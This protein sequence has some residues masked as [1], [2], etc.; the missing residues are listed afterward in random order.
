MK[1]TLSFRSPLSALHSPLSTLHSPL[2]ALLL[3]LLLSPISPLHSQNTSFYAVDSTCG[4]D[5]FYTE[6]IQTT[7]EGNLYG[8]RRYD[9]TVLTPPV[10]AYVG[11]FSGGYCQ[12]WQFDTTT[13]PDPNLSEPPLLAGLID[14][15]GRFIVPCAFSAV[16]LPS[17]GR[18]A[19]MQDN[20]WGFADLQGR[21]VVAPRFTAVRP[22]SDGRAAVQTIVDSVFYFGNYIDTLGHLLFPNDYFQNTRSFVDGYATAMRYDRWGVIDRDGNEI[23]P[24]AFE[25][26]TDPD[27]HTVL[28]GHDNGELALFR[29]PSTSPRRQIAP[30]TPFIYHPLSNV[31]QNRIAVLRGDKQGFLDLQ[32]NEVIPC[33][34]DEVGIFR[35]GRTMV[36][37]GDLYGIIDT[38]GDTILPIAYHSHSSHGT[39]YAYFDSLAL[40]EQN[41]RYGF[42][43]LDGRFVV[44]LI[45]QSAYHFTEGLAPVQKDGLWG[46]IDTSGNLALPLIFDRAS[47]FQHRRADVTFH[48][49][50]VKI[51]PDGHC[52]ANCGNI[53]S[54]K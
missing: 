11:Q 28:A 50:H 5:I 12:V 52:V 32:G 49:R 14:S 33:V 48:G 43:D 8:F 27:H 9:G 24:F 3:L 21:I 7:R 53:I 40:V 2:S 44:P 39:K 15:T 20:L 41:Y 10:F 46:Y 34:Y 30:S 51:D 1:K 13:P 36:R 4:C 23:V 17:Q 16:D 47:P 37:N 29:L 18:I 38:L 42:V 45:L 35:L 26:L 25:L 6:G 31:S 19:V 54:F 22:F